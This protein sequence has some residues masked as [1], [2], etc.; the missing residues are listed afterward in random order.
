MYTKYSFMNELE[1]AGFNRENIKISEYNS[2][3]VDFFLNMDNR[4]NNSFYIEAKK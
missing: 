2:S 3:N 1:M 4:P